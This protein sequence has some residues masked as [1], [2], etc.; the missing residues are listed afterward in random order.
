MALKGYTSVETVERALG[1]ALSAEHRTSL[2]SLL[3]GVEAFIDG[4]CGRGWLMGTITDE[5][6]WLPRSDHLYVFNPP[7]TSVTTVKARSGI[8][9]ADAT[10]T[11]N[12]DWEARD[13]ELGI[14]YVI[15]ATAYDRIK[16]TYI[17]PA[18]LPDDIAYV[19]TELG[20]VTARMLLAGTG[21]EIQSYGVGGEIQVV[22]FDTKIVPGRCRDIM[23]YNS[24]RRAG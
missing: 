3:P 19:A 13:P 11:A 8:G 9:E 14:V 7:F 16:I 10:L 4:Q 15:G 18:T 22:N 20:A 21:P 24:F 17:T 2:A 6:H 5:T 23:D 1:H 12:T